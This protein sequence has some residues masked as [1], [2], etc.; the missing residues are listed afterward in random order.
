MI[1]RLWLDYQR[2]DPSR[3][4][5]GLIVLGIGVAASIGE[6]LS[7]SSATAEL[8]AS[9]ASVTRLRRD[10]AQPPSSDGFRPRPADL[11][12]NEAPLAAARPSASAPAVAYTRARWEL[13]F[14][15]LEA[16][17]A[18]SVTLLALRPESRDVKLTGEAVNL[19][20][21]LDYLTRLQSGNAFGKVYLTQSEVVR[22]H[23]QRPV[24]FTLVAEWR[25][26]P[27]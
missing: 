21:A 9:Q 24:K 4:I 11:S 8:E 1:P 3:R 15:S 6:I 13:L 5:P 10:T 12:G 26:A 2:P 19:D 18:E 16:A 14:S 22:E 25:E 27:Q 23:P 7:Y 17:A 20:A